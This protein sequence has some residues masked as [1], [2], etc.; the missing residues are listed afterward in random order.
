MFFFRH[1]PA[2]AATRHLG[3]PVSSNLIVE[4][5]GQCTLSY[6]E[7][8]EIMGLKDHIYVHAQFC[9]RVFLGLIIGSYAKYLRKR[10]RGRAVTLDSIIMIKS[11]LGGGRRLKGRAEV[12]WKQLGICGKCKRSV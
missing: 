7:L 12:W 9:S 1:G 4:I 3:T 10:G 5:Q 8:D 2:S 11:C 6:Q